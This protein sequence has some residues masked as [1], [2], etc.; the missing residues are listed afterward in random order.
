VTTV[1][2]DFVTEFYDSTEG[3]FTIRPSPRGETRP[4]GQPGDL[5]AAVWLT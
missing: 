1:R 4:L 5:V 2:I 3:R